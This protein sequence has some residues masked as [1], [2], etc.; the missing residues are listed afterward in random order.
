[1]AQALEGEGTAQAVNFGTEDLSEA[2]AA[3]VE[4]RP[5]EFRGR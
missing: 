1:L 5:P 3:Y 2:L 4:K